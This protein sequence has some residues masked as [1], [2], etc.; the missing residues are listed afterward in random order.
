MA[1]DGARPRLPLAKMSMRFDTIHVNIKDAY[2][3]RHEPEALRLIARTYWATLVIG[4]LIVVI[5]TIGY[6][7]WEFF[8]TPSPDESISGV[9]PQSAFT[10]TQLQELLQQFDAR[11]TSFEESMKAPVTTKDPS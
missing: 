6:G 11:G 9:R 5:S 7:V 8:R 4:L 3:A 10:R 1:R 2:A